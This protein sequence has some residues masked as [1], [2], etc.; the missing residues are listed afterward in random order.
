M[1]HGLLLTIPLAAWHND[2]V[3]QLGAIGFVYWKWP[4]PTVV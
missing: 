2:P 4:P 3:G 1:G